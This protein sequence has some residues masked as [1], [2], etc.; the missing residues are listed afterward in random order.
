MVCLGLHF[1]HATGNSSEHATLTLAMPYRS[2][3]YTRAWLSEHCRNRHH[4]AVM[5]SDWP[6]R[7]PNTLAVHGRPLYFLVKKEEMDD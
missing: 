5:T 1:S 2:A 6:P 7:H 4:D 3:T